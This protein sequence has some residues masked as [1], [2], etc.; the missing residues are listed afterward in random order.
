MKVVLKVLERTD[1]LVGCGLDAFPYMHLFVCE[2]HQLVLV[3]FCRSFVDMSELVY[4]LHYAAKVMDSRLLKGRRY[5]ECCDY[6][7]YC[8]VDAGVQHQ[9]PQKQS[10]SYIECL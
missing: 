7:C 1:H 8:R 4:I 9:V 2:D 6:A 10:H 3:L 5:A